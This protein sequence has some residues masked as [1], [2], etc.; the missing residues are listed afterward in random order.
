MTETTEVK[1][2][3][4]EETLFEKLVKIFNETWEL[5]QDIKDLIDQAKEDE[6]EDVSLIKTIA[7]AKAY[8]KISDLEDKAKAQLQKI[9][10]LA[11]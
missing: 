6:V 7:K 4:T 3:L 5:D 11:G 9:Q 1:E 8:N 10:D 2:K